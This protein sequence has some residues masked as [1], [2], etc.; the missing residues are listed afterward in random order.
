MSEPTHSQLLERIAKLETFAETLRDDIGEIKG[1]VKS[2]TQKADMGAGALWLLF[3]I[4]A[5]IAG[6]GAAGA[7]LMDKVIK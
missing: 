3:K 7:W 2:L 5:V 6:L 4:A 1:D